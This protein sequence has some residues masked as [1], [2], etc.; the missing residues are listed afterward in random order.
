MSGGNLSLALSFSMAMVSARLLRTLPCC[1][2]GVEWKDR[3]RLRGFRCSAISVEA[4]VAGISGI[5]WGSSKL[6]GARSEMEDEVVLR[7]DGLSGFSFAAVLDGHAGFSCVEFLREELYKECVTAMQGGLLLTNNNFGVVREAIEKVFANVDAR[8]SIWLEQTGKDIES[9]ATATVMFVRNDALIISHVGDSCVVI[10]RR[11]KAEMLT[12][13]HRPYGNNRVSL[14]E[15]KRV[16]AAGGWIVDGRI[17]GDLAISRT[18]GD[19]RYKSKKNEM[20]MK[21]VKQGRWNDKFVSRIQFKADIVTSSPDISQI[22]LSSD[23]EFVL[24]AS[25]GLWDYMKSSEAVSFVRDQLRQHGDVQIACEALARAALDRHS[26]DNISIIIADLGRTDWQN[27]P[28]QGPNYPYEITQAFATVGV[29]FLGIWLS[30][31]LGI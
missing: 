27:L 13:P 19:I 1:G 6:Q 4:P 11:G 2:I 15:I 7:S 29:V 31:F 12:N 18:F 24:L 23:V 8:L 9:G 3:R 28:V 16:R 22:E 14:E 21:G 17:C 30:S 26:Q 10:S 5:R 20:L 25:D